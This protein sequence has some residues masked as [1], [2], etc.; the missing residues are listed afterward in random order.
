MISL[1]GEES[2]ERAIAAQQSSRKCMSVSTELIMWAVVSVGEAG[3]CLMG[4]V[5]AVVV[6]ELPPPLLDGLDV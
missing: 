3:V 5:Q 4:G 2:N 1:A 6:R